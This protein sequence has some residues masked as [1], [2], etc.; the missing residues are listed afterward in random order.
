M[1]GEHFLTW[2]TSVH[3]QLP[4]EA[5]EGDVDGLDGDPLVCRIF[6]VVL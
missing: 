3:T 6:T 2:L 5:A 4:R 1:H